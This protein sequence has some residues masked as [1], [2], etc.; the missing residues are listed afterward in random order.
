LRWG[1]PTPPKAPD[2]PFTGTIRA[3]APPANWG[4]LEPRFRVCE[5]GVE[6]SPIDLKGATRA[7]LGQVRPY[8]QPMR[9]RVLNNGH[10]VQV[11]AE[12]GSYSEI[13]GSRYELLQFHFHH[14]SE[15]TLNGET[16]PLEVHFVHRGEQGQLAVLGVFFRQGN[17]NLELAKVFDSMPADETP[18]RETG[19][20]LDPERLLPPSRAYYRYMGSLTT[21]PCSQ[22]VLWTVFRDPI[23]ASREQVQ[24]FSQIFPLNARPIQPLNARFLLENS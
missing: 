21:P 1:K 7:E 20:T 9:M 4:G 12:P 8:F 10:T 13:A 17:T 22:N 24:Q 6:Q 23:E 18:E 11:N 2:I 14:P 3:R 5:L 15:H 19:V 16:F